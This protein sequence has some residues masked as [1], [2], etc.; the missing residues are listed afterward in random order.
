MTHAM[1]L[2]NMTL[3]QK[4]KWK[5]PYHI[6]Y[7]NKLHLG[8]LQVFRCAAYIY[9]PDEKHPNKLAPKAELMV[10]LGRPEGTKGWLFMKQ[11]NSIFISTTAV[12]DESWFPRCKDQSQPDIPDSPPDLDDDS[13]SDSEPGDDDYFTSN[14]G[15]DDVVYPCWGQAPRRGDN[16]DEQDLPPDHDWYDPDPQDE[17]PPADPK[18]MVEEEEEETPPIHHVATLSKIV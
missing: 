18:I 8:H 4:L 3:Q 15:N 2:Y 13:D 9:L 10:Y 5:S 12:F 11:N 16:D 1:H 7:G 17:K 14:E 6:L